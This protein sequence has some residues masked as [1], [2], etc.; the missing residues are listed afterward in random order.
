MAYKSVWKPLLGSTASRGKDMHL[1]SHLAG[2]AILKGTEAAAVIRPGSY[3]ERPDA[4]AL[5][6]LDV[7]EGIVRCRQ[8][9]LRMLRSQ[10]LCL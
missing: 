3:R 9:E 2:K 4:E 1:H 8:Q 7:C 10:N 6:D 5:P